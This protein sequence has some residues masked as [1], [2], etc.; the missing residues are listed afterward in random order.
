[1]NVGAYQPKFYWLER[2]LI[3]NDRFGPYFIEPVIAGISSPE[4]GSKPFIAGA[5]LI[6]CLNFA[7]DFIVVG[8]ASEELFGIAEGLW[9]P[10]LVCLFFQSLL[11][12][13]FA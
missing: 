12:L 8:T 2:T 10:D 4:R 6:G 3:I 7:K 5:D 9:E 1:M 13:S 11:R